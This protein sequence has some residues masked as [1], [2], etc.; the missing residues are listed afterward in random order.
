MK[1]FWHMLYCLDISAKKSDASIPLKLRL[2]LKQKQTPSQKQNDYSYTRFLKIY[3]KWYTVFIY[4]FINLSICTNLKMEFGNIKARHLISIYE[5]TYI[6][7]LF[8][9]FKPKPR[10]QISTAFSQRY[11]YYMIAILYYFSYVPFRFRKVQNTKTGDIE[12]IFHSNGLQKVKQTQYKHN[13]ARIFNYL[14]NLIVT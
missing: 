13:N 4:L 1:H 6:P 7:V 8:P 3:F 10:T 9:K 5:F 2:E 14:L 11:I 12:I